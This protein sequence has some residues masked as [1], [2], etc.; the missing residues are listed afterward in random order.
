MNQIKETLKEAT[1]GTRYEGK[2]YYV[3]GA[4]R[5]KFIYNGLSDE[6]S[7]NTC[8]L[9]QASGDEDIDIVLVGDAEKLA[10]FLYSEGIADHPPVTY[11]RFG[12]AMINVSGCQVE[13]VGARVESYNSSSRKPSTRP[14]TLLDDILRRDFTIN[15]LLE[16]IH[17][18]EIRD[19]TGCG[20]QDIKDKIIRTPRDPVITF[21]DDPLRMLRAVRF[22]VRF[23]FTIHPDTYAAISDRADRLSIVSKERIR[24]EFVKILMTSRAV[25]GLEILRRT[26]LLGQFAPELS[27]MYGVTQNIYHKYDVWTHTMKTLESFLDDSGINMRLAALFHDVGKPQTKSVDSDGN[28][29]FY[30]H[31]HVGADIARQ[32]MHRLRFSN[33][34]I[35][36][37][38]FLISMHLRVGEYDNKWSDTAVR[39]LLHNAGGHLEDLIRLTE[40]DKAASNTEMPS[41]DIAALRAHIEK[42]QT[43]LA[44]HKMQS[45]LSGRE[46]MDLTGIVQGP[47]IGRI[48]KYLEREVIEG[49]LKAGDKI[50]AAKLLH[51]MGVISER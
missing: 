7:H 27:A 5:D 23:G 18:G 29:H 36:E 19:L 34:E 40:A 6:L 48:K 41:V 26:K 25:E 12:T 37:V 31:Q 21:D 13:L 51:K 2:L 9:P 30:E 28:V 50:E 38:A 24:V 35:D 3:G 4:V 15:T 45:P 32:V 16:N 20:F 17:T 42:I 49:K 43:Q 8:G 14:G 33:S 22:A 10:D 47:Q 1:K 11:P 46:I 39:R 44:G